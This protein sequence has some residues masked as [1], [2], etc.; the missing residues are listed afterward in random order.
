MD[1]SKKSYFIT[2]L[3]GQLN[4]L[5]E[6]TDHF[7]PRLLV[8]MMPPPATYKI[9][10]AAMRRYAQRRRARPAHFSQAAR[11]ITTRGHFQLY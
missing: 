1:I 8:T 7:T 11:D 2:G 6:M 10:A 4:G 3:Y 9:P 5:I